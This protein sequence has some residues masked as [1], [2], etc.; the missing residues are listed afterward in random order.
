LSLVEQC[1]MVLQ[2]IRA[3]ICC[4]LIFAKT[5][6]HKILFTQLFKFGCVKNFRSNVFRVWGGK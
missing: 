1:C 2:Q 3:W 4:S 6:L 5:Y